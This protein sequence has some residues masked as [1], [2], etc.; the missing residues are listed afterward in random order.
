MRM[1][2]KMKKSQNGLSKKL[3]MKRINTMM[4]MMIDNE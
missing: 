1:R 2:M 4:N 3:D